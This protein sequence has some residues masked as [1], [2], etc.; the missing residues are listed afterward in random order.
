M[1]CNNPA[2]PAGSSRD[3]PRHHAENGRDYYEAWPPCPV[4]GSDD[5]EARPKFPL[6]QDVT[7][8]RYFLGLRYNDP[9]VA[10]PPPEGQGAFGWKSPY[11]NDV[12]AGE[13]NQV[14]LYRVEF[15]PFDDSL[16][17]PSMPV[18]E[19]LNDPI[20]F[21]RTAMNGESTARPCCERWAEVA[22]VMGIGKYQDLV[23]GTY[24]SGNV[25]A[26]EPATTFRFSAVS[27][28]TFTG[29]Y[30]SDKGFGYPN[31]VPAV[32]QADYG[33]W[34]D[35]SPNIPAAMLGDESAYNY[36]VTV[37]RDDHTIAYYT[38]RNSSGH[39]VVEKW[40]SGGVTPSFDITQ[41]LTTGAI[42]NPGGG[43]VEMAYTV[44]LNRGKVNFALDP[45]D[46]GDAGGHACKLGP[47]GINAA[48][49]TTYD[50]DRGSARRSALLTTFDPA[51]GAGLYLPNARIVPGS[52]RVM[53]PE[54]TLGPSY[55][56]AVRYE[57]V[58][59]SLGE[60]GPKQ[61]KIDY[62]TGWIYFSSV[63]GADL[64]EI[65][66]STGNALPIYVDYK[67]QFNRDG[68]IVKGDYITKSMVTVHLGMRMFDPESAKPHSV[69]LTNS[70]K[71][72]NALR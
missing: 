4:C 32:Y 47:A 60:P 24:V 14:V 8:V 58:A 57:R 1:H 46:P 43:E 11:G 7:V 63:F 51:R 17:P 20:F 39:M 56:S 34:I 50:V 41:Y 9:N 42:T 65:L 23:V 36:A 52:E 61:Y 48:F 49:H 25:T 40:T 70:V 16:F 68:D 12:A 29:A 28:D 62:D 18:A 53:G 31:A 10:N 5:I 3:Y 33:Y 44:D 21:Y 2:H 19:R 6:E 13:E 35:N 30:S 71:V 27:N 38:R 15:N 45:P 66:D 54:P 26:V 69:D 67:I 72:R 37:T 22:Q 64:P 59:L 55:G